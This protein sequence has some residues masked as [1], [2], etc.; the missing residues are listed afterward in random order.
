MAKKEPNP[1]KLAQ[2]TGKLDEVI[3][4]DNE[5]KSYQTEWQKLRGLIKASYIKVADVDDLRTKEAGTVSWPDADVLNDMFAKV[6]K[7]KVVTQGGTKNRPK[8][9]GIG[10][11]LKLY[12]TTGKG[13]STLTE[14]DERFISDKPG[15][16]EC[17]EGA[18]LPHKGISRDQGHLLVRQTLLPCENCGYG[19]LKWAASLDSMILVTAEKGYDTIRDGSV[20]F[21]GPNAAKAYYI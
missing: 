9:D 18:I 7:M 6:Q 5:N 10:F 15:A 2:K 14:L 11:H 20:F 13:E 21:F 8:T 12:N 4:K 17:F 1:I 16:A 19:Y 3:V